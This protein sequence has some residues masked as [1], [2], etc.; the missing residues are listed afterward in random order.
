MYR[1]L[2]VSILF[3]AYSSVFA[4]TTGFTNDKRLTEFANRAINIDNGS[5]CTGFFVSSDGYFVTAL[6]CGFKFFM[7]RTNKLPWLHGENLVDWLSG[8]NG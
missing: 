3:L 4:E 8:R 6:H 1:V 2:T 5:A 7:N